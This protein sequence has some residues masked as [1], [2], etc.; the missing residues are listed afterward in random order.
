MPKANI[1]FVEE[2]GYEA[3]NEGNMVELDQK[4]TKQREMYR[5]RKC[6]EK[7]DMEFIWSKRLTPNQKQPSDLKVEITYPFTEHHTSFDLFSANILI[8][9]H[10]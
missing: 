8:L 2:A 4:I 3:N 7:R 6:K 10:Q 9:K 5:K 1:H